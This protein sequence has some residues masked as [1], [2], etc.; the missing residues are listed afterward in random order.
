M[1][2]AAAVSLTAVAGAAEIPSSFG[3]GADTYLSNDSNSGPTVTHGNGALNLRYWVNVRSRQ[4]LIRFD[5][6]G[7]SGDKTGATLSLSF[8]RSNRGRTVQVFGLANEALD[9]WDEATTSYSNAPGS[10]YNAGTNVLGTYSYDVGGA[11]TDLGTFVV[12]NQAVPYTDTSSPTTLNL[13][14]FLAADTNGQVSF[15]VVWGGDYAPDWDI[16]SK[17]NANP[18]LH[19]L[20]TVPNATEQDSD[21]DGMPDTWEVANGL[22]PNDATGDNG[23]AGDPDSDGASNLDEYTADTDPQNPLSVPGDSDADGLQDLWEDANFGN[24][25][26]TPD[27]L[28]LALQDGTGDPD[29]DKCTNE[30]EET[31]LTDPNDRLSFLDADSDGVNDCWEIHY[32]GDTTSITAATDDNDSDG[33]DAA[34]EYANFSNP[35]N[36]SSVLGDIDGDG[37]PDLWE[38]QYY[39][40]NNDIVDDSVAGL[41]ELAI[42]DGTL[43]EDSDGFTGLQEGNGS[44]VASDPFNALSVPGDADA[45]N[46]DD[47]WELTYFPDIYGQDGADDSDGDLYTNEEEETAVLDAYGDPCDPNNLY[48]FPDDVDFDLMNDRWEILYFGNITVSDD[49]QE[50]Y[51]SDGS[52]NDDEY[53]FGT[54]PTDP[55][56]IPGDSD[57]DGLADTWEQTYFTNSIW[58]V[59]WGFALSD[60]D[61]TDDPDGDGA[62]NDQEESAGTDPTNPQS[63]PDSDSDGM[64]DAWEIKYFG[65]IITTDIG[66]DDADSDG[67]DNS[68]EFLNLTDPTDPLSTSDSDTDRLPDGWENAYFGN[69]TQ[70]P[71]G[72]FDSDGDSN[73]LELRLGTNP[74]D[75]GSVSSPDSIDT[76]NLFGADIDLA[77]DTQNAGTGP[78]VQNGLLDGMALRVWENV[79]LHIPMVRF[80]VSNVS[81]D[82]SNAMLRLTTTF[83]NTARVN[84]WGLV[85]GSANEG[86]PEATTSFSTSPGLLP[87]GPTTISYWQRD[88]AQV[89]YLGHIDLQPTGQG[90][91]TPEGLDISGFIGDDTDGQITLF[92]TTRAIGN[93]YGVRT[94][95]SN[96]AGTAPTLIFPG[97]I[98]VDPD[99]DSDGL[100]DA[101]EIDNF[102]DLAEVGTG[103]PDSDGFDNEAEETAGTDPNDAGSTPGGGGSN[104][105]I[106]SVSFDTGTNTFTINATG[107]TP[108]NQYHIQSSINLSGFSP[109]VGSTFTAGAAAEARNVAADEAADPTQFFRL[110]DGPEAP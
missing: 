98:T 7:I 31:A 42:T 95:E 96:I 9:N 24:N 37:L 66:T 21:S 94:K 100:A 27:P 102:G 38:D 81:G 5:T 75:A 44:P 109:V 72:D 89:K 58:N 57:G 90:I 110:A 30:E 88:P 84:V 13:D 73:L 69:L 67:E 76:N 17:E 63:A 45:D 4:A 74:N 54:D 101:W 35:N 11:W 87:T 29:N 51:D 93:W 43:D 39:G 80:D 50:D 107:L 85:D 22:D 3:T 49:D 18:L 65:D 1:K 79:R 53:F 104:I 82:L 105:G 103:D 62:T 61:G 48:S 25:D 56:S 71:D 36:A 92:F 46:L 78:T 99:S 86:W 8:T 34:A 55:L 2:L 47:T 59:T 97:G 10:N 83:G 91:S 70:G 60:F 52:V 41:A 14:S 64:G 23:A 15:L 28:E 16:A 19:P 40:D 20:L 108:G 32:M 26:G 12:S 77:N 68:T 106:G 33:Q 6:S